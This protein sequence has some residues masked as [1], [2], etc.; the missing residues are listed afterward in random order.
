MFTLHNR[1]YLC[2]IDYH[3]EFLVM[4][5]MEDLSADSLILA[6]TI[7]FSEYGSLKKIMSDAGGSFISD[8]LKRFCQDINI[9]QI[10]LSSYYNQN[11]GQVGACIKFIR[12]IIKKC[13]DTIS[14]IHL[15]LLQIRSNPQG[16]ILPSPTMLLFNHQIIGNMPVINRLPVNSNN[17]G[18]HYEVLLKKQ[19]KDDKNHETFINYVSFPLGSTVVVQQEGGGLWTHG[20]MVGRGYHNHNNRSYIIYITKTGHV[21]TRNSKHI[22]VIPIMA[23][24]YLWFT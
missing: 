23:E 22:K 16:P 6:C 13:I 24:Q 14:D 9:Q 17:D 18:E 21:I 20:T 1:N 12:C 11:D 4:K 7:I 5:K 10:V 19:A 8:K 3:S 15:A 2:I